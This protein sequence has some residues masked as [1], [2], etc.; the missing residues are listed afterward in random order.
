MGYSE[1][2][3]VGKLP[4]LDEYAN[5][6]IANGMNLAGENAGMAGSG[7]ADMPAEQ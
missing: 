2:E 4:F 7:A 5:A 6:Q 1:S 3:G